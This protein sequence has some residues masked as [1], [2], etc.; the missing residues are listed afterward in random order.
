MN[1][2]NLR[3]KS[4]SRHRRKRLGRGDGS[5]KG[6][7]SGKGMKGQRA[8]SGGRVRP[9]FEGGQTPYVQKMPKLRGFKN[10]GQVT[11]QVVNV[12][13]LE[14]FKAGAEVNVDTLL[15]QGL[16]AKKNLPVKILGDGDLSKKLTIKVDSVSKSA[17]DKIKKAGGQ[18]E[19]TAKH[20]KKDDKKKKEEPKKETEENVAKS[21]PEP[22]P[23]APAK[24]EPKE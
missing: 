3:S 23:E 20:L 11:Y 5:G 14:A 13:D 12:K 18:C 9:G 7:Y 17:E 15:A 6:T 24:E 8:R 19:A 21:E 4:G 1:L 10:P 16:V 2:L 22:A